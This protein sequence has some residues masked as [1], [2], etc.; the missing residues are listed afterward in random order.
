MKIIHLFS[1]S[2]PIAR[3]E[4]KKCAQEMKIKEK[5]FPPGLEPP[6]A[7]RTG[8]RRDHLTNVTR[9]HLMSYV[10]ENSNEERS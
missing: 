2:I 6:T 8:E 1:L 3:N 4:N 10:F 5:V 9:C 7:H